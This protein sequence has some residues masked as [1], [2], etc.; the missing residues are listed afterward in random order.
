MQPT[1]KRTGPEEGKTSPIFNE[2]IN[3]IDKDGNRIPQV[4]NFQEKEQ[5]NKEYQD[6][7]KQKQQAYFDQ[8]QKNDENEATRKYNK[9]KEESPSGIRRSNYDTSTQKPIYNN[10]NTSPLEGLDVDSSNRNQTDPNFSEN[11]FE[12]EPSGSDSG[13]TSASQSTMHS[14][15]V[16]SNPPNV[17]R[18]PTEE[19]YGRQLEGNPYNSPYP[20]IHQRK[21][22]NTIGEASST[23]NRSAE[24]D[25]MVNNPIQNAPSGEILQY[26]NPQGQGNY[27]GNINPN[28]GKPNPPPQGF[29]NQPPNN[30]VFNGNNPANMQNQPF[31]KR[32]KQ[33]GQGNMKNF[34]N[35]NFINPTI[36]P[37]VPPNMNLNMNPQMNQ[38]QYTR[39]GSANSGSNEPLVPLMP[40]PQMSPTN[41]S[42]GKY[43]KNR[44]YPD[45]NQ[46]RPQTSPNMHPN[47]N[48]NIPHLQNMPPNMQYNMPQIQN[49]MIPNMM[50]PQNA[51]ENYSQENMKH[52][53]ENKMPQNAMGFGNN[54]QNNPNMH[55]YHGSPHPYPDSRGM[56]NNIPPQNPYMMSHPPV[57]PEGGVHLFKDPQTGMN[58]MSPV[59]MNQNPQNNFGAP[60]MNYNMPPNQPPINQM[61]NKAQFMQN[62]AFP[63]AQNSGVLD[64]STMQNNI[65]TFHVDMNNQFQKKNFKLK[66]DVN[67]YKLNLF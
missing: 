12:G 48:M 9:P 64:N 8:Q 37:N 39:K 67:C 58:I 1:Q 52:I 40:N 63:H 29:Y 31:Q 30:Q 17:Y 3:Q 28:Q 44:V 14:D 60:P 43:N 21:K 59:G 6:Q 38:N 42:N 35:N 10:D 51:V 22:A 15:V 65:R 26:V 53:K 45:K 50:L 56:V 5:L 34:P 4:S 24:R 33:K 66:A 13:Y 11:Q 47:P 54:P 55:Q 25:Q 19:E 20:S 36:N 62:I 32:G 2:V 27:R 7:R 49:E 46:Q 18:P 23:S 41:T 16:Y 57:Q 61:M